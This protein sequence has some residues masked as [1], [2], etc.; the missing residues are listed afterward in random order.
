MDVLKDYADLL[1]VDETAK[2]LRVSKAVV[3]SLIKENKIRAFKFGRQ[4][5]CPKYDIIEKFLR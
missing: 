3:Y 1:T 2:I 4:Y 5:K